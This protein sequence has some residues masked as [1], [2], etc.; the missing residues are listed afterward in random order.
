VSRSKIRGQR[1]ISLTVKEVVQYCISHQILTETN[2]MKQGPPWEVIATQLMN[3]LHA[4]YGTQKVITVFKIPVTRLHPETH[5]CSYILKP[6]FLYAGFS[7]IL[8]S[9]HMS[10]KCSS[11]FKFSYQEF[12]SPYLLPMRSTGPIHL[13][14]RNVITQQYLINS[15]FYEKPIYWTLWINWWHMQSK[16]ERLKHWVYFQWNS[17]YVTKYLI[18]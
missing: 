12:T 15:T 14:F 3:K 5:Q 8:P 4:L 17:N 9:R 2:S 18:H 1:Y 10:P 16:C 11:S 13:I 7:S 6:P